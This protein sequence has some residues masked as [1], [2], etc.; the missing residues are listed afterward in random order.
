MDELAA[1][2]SEGVLQHEVMF[3]SLSVFG[4]TFFKKGN[5]GRDH[6]AGH[7]ALVMIGEGLNPG[8]VGGIEKSESGREYVAQSIDSQ[9][10]AAGG[11]IPFEETLGAAGKTLGAALGVPEE[12]MDEV[13]RTGKVV[14]SAIA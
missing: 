10:G 12:R 9:T 7:H 1:L 3:G 5:S 4:R 2:R 8:V 14:R 6:N 13:V 11:D